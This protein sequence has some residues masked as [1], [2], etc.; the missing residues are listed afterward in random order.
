MLDHNTYFIRLGIFL[1]A[2]FTEKN[3][4]YFSRDKNHGFSSYKIKLL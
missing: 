2:S 1:G 3:V 4:G